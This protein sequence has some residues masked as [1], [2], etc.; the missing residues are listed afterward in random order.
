MAKLNNYEQKLLDG[1]ED[2]YKKSQL[3]L[4]VLLALKDG[5]KY[6]A[7]IKK[8]IH[9]NSKGTISVDDQSIYRALRRYNDADLVTFREKPASGPDIK[10]YRLTDTGKT[11]LREFVKRN[12]SDIFL[13]PSVQKLLV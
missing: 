4:W 12:I 2:V 7:K 9:V 3:T 8:F 11:V 10:V 13:D 1:W 6:M 5:P